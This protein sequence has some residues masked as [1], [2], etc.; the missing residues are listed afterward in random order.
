[1]KKKT[2]K[3]FSTLCLAGILAVSGSVVAFAGDY[4]GIAP[5][6]DT[7]MPSIVDPGGGGLPPPPP[8]TGGS[9][10]WCCPTFEPF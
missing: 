2:F 3:K 4:E 6:A 10:P 8:I 5:L 7:G 9:P 1:M